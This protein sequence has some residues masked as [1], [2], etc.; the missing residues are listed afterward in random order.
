MAYEDLDAIT[1]GQR[2][3]YDSS[4]RLPLGIRRRCEKCNGRLKAF[5]KQRSVDELETYCECCHI[6]VSFKI[7]PKGIL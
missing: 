5:E 6:M 7:L 2:N 3:E 4:V 1:Q